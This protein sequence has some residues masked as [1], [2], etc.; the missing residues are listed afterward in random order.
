M[1]PLAPIEVVGLPLCLTKLSKRVVGFL[2][3][4][5]REKEPAGSVFARFRCQPLTVNA[6]NRTRVGANAHQKSEDGL[7]KLWGQL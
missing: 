5:N 3:I 2:L 4:D 1:D 6:V 7:P